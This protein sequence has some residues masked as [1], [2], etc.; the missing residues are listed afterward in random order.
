M[1]KRGRAAGYV[2]G[3]EHRDKIT[4]SNVLR[5][6]ISFAEGKIAPEEYPP[7]RVTAALGLLDRIMPKLA[8]T[9]VVGSE[10]DGAIGIVFKTIVEKE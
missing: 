1:A 6:L 10:D 3:P 8:S 2:M 5:G 9:E 4:N 7:H